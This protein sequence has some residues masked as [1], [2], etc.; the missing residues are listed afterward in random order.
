MPITSYIEPTVSD[1]LDRYPRFSTYDE[2][3]V[4]FTLDL[5]ID[6]VGESWLVKD[7]ANA[8]MLLCAHWLVTESGDVTRPGIV[9]SE[10]FG[11]M[12]VSYA[13]QGTLNSDYSRTE[14]GQRYAR[15]LRLNFPGIKIAQ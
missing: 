3:L 9:A 12:S 1:F 11:P 5:A 4:H 8:Q 2:Y 10:S 13:T 15:L 7:R 6:T 14:Y